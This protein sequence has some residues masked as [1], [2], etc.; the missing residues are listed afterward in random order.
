MQK[1]YV[2]FRC[3]GSAMVLGKFQ[4]ATKYRLKYNRTRVSCGWTWM[5][6]LGICDLQG[7]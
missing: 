2:S 4:Q 1:N 5:Q 6:A 3:E 7:L